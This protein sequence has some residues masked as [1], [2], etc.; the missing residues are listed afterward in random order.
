MTHI[1]PFVSKKFYQLIKERSNTFWKEALVRNLK[2]DP[3]LWKQGVL[4]L[5]NEVKYYFKKQENNNQQIIN[6]NNNK[7][8]TTSPSTEHS[9][10]TQNE[11]TNNNEDDENENDNEDWNKLADEA[12]QLISS[13]SSETVRQ[14]NSNALL[15]YRYITNNYIRFSAPVFHMPHDMRLGHAFGLHFFEPRYR[16]LIAHV[17]KHFSVEAKSGGTIDP[18][19]NLMNNGKMPQFIYEHHPKLMRSAPAYIVEV[20]S[21]VIYQNGRADVILV[22]VAKVAIETIHEIPN[23]GQLFY[24][25]VLRLSK[26]AVRRSEAR[27]SMVLRRSLNVDPNDLAGLYD[28]DDDDDSESGSGSD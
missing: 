22:P 13:I 4:D 27:N 3:S 28:D 18:H 5:R 6:N 2:S 15:A 20:K 16:I 21:C 23:T 8:D 17:M 10:L 11:L 14:N 1:L 24:A 12:C 26:S 9:T 7:T 19:N 25:R